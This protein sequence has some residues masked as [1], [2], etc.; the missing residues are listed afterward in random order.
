[1]IEDKML[2]L[3]GGNMAAHG[4]DEGYAVRQPVTPS[5]VKQHLEGTNGIGIYPMWF[6][7][8]KWW[9]KWGCCDIDTGDWSEAY[10]L[11]V[12]LKAMGLVPFVERSRSKGWHVWVFSDGP[13]EAKHM[14]RCLK[15]A[16][17]AIDLPAREANPKAEDLRPDQLGNYVRLP[18]KGS[19]TEPTE[20]QTMMTGWGPDTDG[21]PVRVVNWFDGFDSSLRIAPEVVEFWSSKWKE[22]ERSRFKTTP[23]IS[24]DELRTLA[25][26]MPPELF[27]FLK[28]GPKGFGDRSEG[29]VAFAFKL[30]TAGYTPEERF[31][32]VQAADRRWGKYHL[33]PDGD[34]YLLDIVERTL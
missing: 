28:D 27:K 7:N 2:H 8:E 12:A 33:R 13:V 22:P 32:L 20:R 21:V 16:Y 15:V 9:V 29:L 34:T 23:V 31:G 10:G 17:A 19:L 1:M 3:F 4:S 18:F 25:V 26:G 24:D 11:C 6:Q 5:L 14:R 30:K